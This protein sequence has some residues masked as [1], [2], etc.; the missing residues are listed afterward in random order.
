[1][2]LVDIWRAESA[3]LANRQP[4]MLTRVTVIIVIITGRDS[5]T[6]TTRQ[7]SEALF[8]LK[9][10]FNDSKIGHDLY[11]PGYKSCW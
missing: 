9:E 5:F 6:T 10:L 11:L 3:L 2:L 4:I 8:A 7:L 1:M